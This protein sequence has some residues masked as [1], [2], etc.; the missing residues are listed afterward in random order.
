M[1]EEV[2]RQAR[3]WTELDSARILFLASDLREAEAL[4]LLRSGPDD[5]VHLV[6]R[7]YRT[8]GRD[9]V[10]RLPPLADDSSASVRRRFVKL[11]AELDAP[12]LHAA[13]LDM[14]P[15]STGRLRREIVASIARTRPEGAEDGLRRALRR[16]SKP[17]HQ[18]IILAGLKEVATSES[19]SALEPLLK[20]ESAAVRRLAA[21][22]LARTGRG[23]DA[24]RKALESESE[25]GP[26]RALRIAL[27]SVGGA[28]AL[29][30]M[31]SC[32]ASPIRRIDRAICL[33]GIAASP[34]PRATRVLHG[35]LTTERSDLRREA[36]MLLATR[37]DDLART[38]LLQAL[39]EEPDPTVVRF[40]ITS[41]GRVRENRAAPSLKKLLDDPN[42]ALY[43]ALS[44]AELGLS[45]G[46]EVIEFALE[47]PEYRM[48]AAEAA[49]KIGFE[50]F[51]EPL[52]A[53]LKAART[54]EQ[55]ARL[56]EIISRLGETPEAEEVPSGWTVT[57]SKSKAK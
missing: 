3:A 18:A 24:L 45:D 32:I 1:R 43:A 52:E 20:S 28:P 21:L 31:E 33:E 36:A 11:A 17:G 40:L 49:G 39:P 23:S 16:E 22:A 53:A 57:T 38:A 50:S 25:R 48:V 26:R 4:A 6:A 29:T 19:A 54:T 13:V 51:R 27:G 15:E 9:G 46:D 56:V 30:E 10:R 42:V 37:D 14:L 35:V 5:V 47:V 55:K 8:A 2:L 7:Y 34:L 41:L 12:D 44:L